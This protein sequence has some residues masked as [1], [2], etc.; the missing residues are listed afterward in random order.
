LPGYNARFV[1]P[2]VHRGGQ[3]RIAA[4]HEV[5]G[6]SIACKP[7]L[8]RIYTL[9]RISGEAREAF[10]ANLKHLAQNYGALR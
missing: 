5:D 7:P 2:E 9:L 4:Y 10:D 1:R 8:N 3:V 6:T